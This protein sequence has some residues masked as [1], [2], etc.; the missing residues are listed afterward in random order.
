MQQ[1]KLDI[2]V[3]SPE[4]YQDAHAINLFYRSI[5]HAVAFNSFPDFYER[6]T[7]KVPLNA[8][9]KVWFLENINEGPKR[10]YEIIKR[11][12][13][14]FLSII[15]GIGVVILSP[16]IM[17]AIKLDSPGPVFFRQKRTGRGG[18]IFEIIKFR[19][20]RDDAEKGI[21]AV[22]AQEYDPRVTRV[23]RFLRKTR[24]DEFPQLWNVLTGSMSFVG[25]RAERPEFNE[26]LSG[27]VP[28]YEERYLI[29]PGLTGWAQIKYGYGASIKDTAEKV[30]YDLYYIKHRSLML[31]LGIILKTINISLRRAGR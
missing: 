3:I 19:S 10:S 14:V 5:G 21:G 6:V 23:G 11:A 18:K 25:P 9:D 29:K 28:F 13:D 31:D 20:M 24:I 26:K 16:L 1:D 15:L 22:W 12:V 7:G 4:A 17:L 30:Q 27:G 8:I 2:V